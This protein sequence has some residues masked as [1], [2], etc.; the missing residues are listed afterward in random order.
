MIEMRANKHVPTSPSMPS[1]KF[2]KLIIEID[3]KRISEAKIPARKG[4]ND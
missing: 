3:N 4:V 2:T 1:M